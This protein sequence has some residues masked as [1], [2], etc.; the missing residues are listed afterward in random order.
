MQLF[1]NNIV[2]HIM[3]HS[4]YLIP[5]IQASYFGDYGGGVYDDS[6]CCEAT[7]DP[8][9]IWTLNHE[10]TVVGYG[11]EAGMDYWLIKNSWGR[12]WGDSGYMKIKRGTGHCGIGNQ[13][14]IQ[15]YCA[16]N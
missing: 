9:C 15:P 11:Q 7:T 3:R 12:G 13:H 6:R 2:Q 8:D 1:H 16:A 5:D 4:L 10:I 14:V